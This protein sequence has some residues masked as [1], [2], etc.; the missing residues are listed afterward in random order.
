MRY[1]D[2]L[3]VGPEAFLILRQRLF[4]HLWLASPPVKSVRTKGEQFSLGK[5][6]TDGVCR[7]TCAVS[8]R[9]SELR[10]W[11]ARTAGRDFCPQVAAGPV[12]QL[13]G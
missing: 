9:P 13:A 6:G 5:A 10:E 7:R 8:R 1:A 3:Q 12:P 11:P 4:A 2:R